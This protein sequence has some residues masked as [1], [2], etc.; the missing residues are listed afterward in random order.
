[1][2]LHDN[3]SVWVEIDGVP[4]HAGSLKPSFTSG[5]V[6]AASSFEYSAEYLSHPQKY[7]LDPSLP[8]VPGRMYASEDHILFGAFRD[9]APDLWGQAIINAAHTREQTLSRRRQTQLGEFD[10]LTHA[11]DKTR[12]GAIRFTPGAAPAGWLGEGP[13][14]AA[15]GDINKL[16]AAAARFEQ[17]TATPDDLAMLEAPG[18]TMGGARPKV[19]IEMNGSLKLLKLP[20]TRDTGDGEAWEAVALDLAR[21]ARIRTPQYSLI[22]T[23]S[24]Q[25]TLQIDRFDR[26]LSG[27]RIG[28]IS[29]RTALEL[30]TQR[31]H[32]VTYEDFADTIDTLTSS[33]EAQLAEMF[34]RVAHTVLINNVDDHWQNHGFIRSEQG[35]EL[36]PVFDVNP[37]SIGSAMISRRINDRDDAT[38]RDIRFLMESAGAY[39]LTEVEASHH[40][41]TVLKATE[42]WRERATA[43]G[44]SESEIESMALAFS[45]EQRQA[46][47][48]LLVGSPRI[49]HIPIQGPAPA[50]GQ[51]RPNGAH[52]GAAW[53]RPHTRRG[54]AVAGH[55]RETPR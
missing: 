22:K 14:A 31:H 41:Y 53:V 54:K 42:Q 18:S 1:M 6:L 28:Y 23:D 36:S 21:E 45:D 32:D 49:V 9:V 37:K 2:G 4:I 11:H 27:N 30:G 51:E 25:S 7:A 12:M 43:R 55:W 29:A 5:R 39:R 50:A 3:L 26:T 34:R 17:N 33:D 19:S 10:H 44:I 48:D 24:G 16:A 15:A 13:G 35:W 8:L 47:E 20:S 40:L 52:H 38:N 46:A